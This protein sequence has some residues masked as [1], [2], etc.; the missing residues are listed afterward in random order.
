MPDLPDPPELPEIEFPTIDWSLPNIDWNLVPTC[1]LLR[2]FGSCEVFVNGNLVWRKSGMNGNQVNIIPASFKSSDSVAIHVD[3]PN[4]MSDPHIGALC[5]LIKYDEGKTFSDTHWKTS[6]R[7]R[8]GWH[9]EHYNDGNWSSAHAFNRHGE[10]PQGPIE[11]GVVSL[12]DDCKWIWSWGTFDDA[13]FRIDLRDPDSKEKCRACNWYDWSTTEAA[14][15]V[16]RNNERHVYDKEDENK[17][18]LRTADEMLL[19]S[20][21]MII[22]YNGEKVLETSNISKNRWPAFAEYFKV[23]FTSTES[24]NNGRRVLNIPVKFM[25]AAPLTLPEDHKEVSNVT[26]EILTEKYWAYTMSYDYQDIDNDSWIQFAYF[27][28]MKEQV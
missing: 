28:E 20:P 27:Y 5:C 8:H 14:K 2:A 11:S 12:P 9:M 7:Y 25:S 17:T 18:E 13:W 1:M 26:L 21:Y 19:T 15:K 6:Y 3:R 4:H 22:Q 24:N 10:E 23:E 16:K